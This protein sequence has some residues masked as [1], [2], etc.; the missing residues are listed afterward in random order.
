ME[1]QNK[2]I[3]GISCDVHNC[4][5]HDGRSKCLAGNI[6]VGPSYASSS[7]DT[8]CATFKPQS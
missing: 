6:N 2:R 8:V 3:E 1:K 5:Y 7:A 4:R